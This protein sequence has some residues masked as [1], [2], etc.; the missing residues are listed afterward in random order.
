MA[1][2]KSTGATFYN[3]IVWQ[4][5]RTQKQIDALKAAGHEPMV[6]ER[7][8]LVLDPYFSASKLSWLLENVPAAAAA[9][10]VGNLCLC[11]L[12]SYIIF[13]LTGKYVTDPSTASRTSLMNIETLTWDA[14]LCDLFNVPLSTLPAIV[15][16]TAGV[17]SYGTF[18]TKNLTIPIVASVVDQTAALYGHNC[19][20]AG[21]CKVT[22]GTGAFV[23]A[24]TG[25]SPPAPPPGL[26][27]V[28]AWQIKGE[29]CVYALDG[30]VYN[31]ASAVNWLRDTGV[32]T[33]YEELDDV[34]E[35]DAEDTTSVL[36]SQGLA[37]VPA[38]SGL[39]CPYYDR[40]AAG[41]CVRERAS[42]HLVKTRLQNVAGASFGGTRSRIERLESVI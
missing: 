12:D 22:F 10:T 17:E 21:Q 13:K 40:D 23:L 36:L 32:F 6:R 20:A 16:T 24:C 34:F 33:K 25:V 1:F 35:G 19:R 27:G 29:E 37:F 28:A 5:A 4:D 30:G 9:E 41:K 7:S 38:L 26:L 15:P 14:E 11:T 3:A 2:D 42:K 31:A 8:G 39:S 18:T